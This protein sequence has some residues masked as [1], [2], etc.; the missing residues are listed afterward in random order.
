[1]S[2]ANAL[3]CSSDAMPSAIPAQNKSEKIKIAYITGTSY[4]GSTLASF[5]LNTHPHIFSPGEMGPGASAERDG[6]PCSCGAVLAACPFYVKVAQ[7]I[8]ERGVP[9]DL[10]HWMLR[11][12]FS[13]KP[14]ID[15]LARGSLGGPFFEGLRHKLWTV[16][17]SYR[18]CVRQ[19]DRRNE[20]FVRAS[21]EVSAK[22][23]FLDATKHPSRIPELRRISSFDLRVIHLI[24]D[25]RGYCNSAFKKRGLPIKAGARRWVEVNR[26]AELQLRALP[27]DGWLRVSYE[28]LARRP[29]SEFSTLAKF[30]GADP[31]QLPD[32][33]RALPHHIVGSRMRLAS[34]QTTIEIDETWKK[35][36]SIEDLKSISEIS[37][38]LARKYGYD[39]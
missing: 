15:R 33:F 22:R 38:S 19:F 14:R 17:R 1:M 8:Q 5:I 23:I 35:E 21:L 24:R 26:A 34:H 25:P 29:Y 9:F 39:I 27:R 12:R 31:F 7:Q 16:L 10:R 13:N 3:Q 18:D 6:Y 4:C 20:A 30:V 28:L 32:N 11:Y 2:H 36:L 37:S